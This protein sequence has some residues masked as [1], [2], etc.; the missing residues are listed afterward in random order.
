M[1]NLEEK[2][3]K[4]E[5]TLS[6]WK[7]RNLTLIG[8]INIVKSLGLSKLIFSASVLTMP[9]RTVERINRIIFNFIWDGKPANHAAWKIIPEHAL[10][11]HD[12]ISFFTQCQYDMKFSDLRS[13]P[14]FYRAIL[15]YWHNN[16]EG[17]ITEC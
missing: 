8:K 11:Q 16:I 10:S 5:K 12:G 2:I 6:C 14:E 9:R 1:L 17:K 7:R 15:N 13:L 3:A 4:L